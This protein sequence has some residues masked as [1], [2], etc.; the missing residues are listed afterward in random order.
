MAVARV[1]PEV[2]AE[3]RGGGIRRSG[4]VLVAKAVTRECSNSGRSYWKRRSLLGS[5]APSADQRPDHC[6]LFTEGEFV[7]KGK[8]LLTIDN[9]RSEA[10]MKQMEAQI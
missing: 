6:S 5:Y 2:K 1:V 8:L 3:A 4:F 7:T 10:Q 9:G